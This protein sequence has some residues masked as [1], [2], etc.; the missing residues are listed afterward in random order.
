MAA[1]RPDRQVDAAKGILSSAR[2]EAWRPQATRRGPLAREYTQKEAQ[3]VQFR[4]LMTSMITITAIMTVALALHAPCVSAQTIDDLRKRIEQLEQSTRE[5]ERSTREQV[6]LLKRQIEQQETAR[7]Q[8]RRA[9][10]EREGPAQTL[11][12]EG[13]QQALRV[14]TQ[15]EEGAEGRAS[16]ERP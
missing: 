14:S 6:N 15:G 13:A 11:E 8:E 2:T 16:G 1:I 9:A 7:G 5:Q 3:M 12:D 10:K 4:R